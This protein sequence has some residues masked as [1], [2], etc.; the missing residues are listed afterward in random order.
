MILNI[1]A[2][3]R[4][5]EELREEYRA[6]RDPLERKKI[7]YKAIPWKTARKIAERKRAL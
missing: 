1:Y 2:I 4:K 6:A 3:D 7:E 5:L